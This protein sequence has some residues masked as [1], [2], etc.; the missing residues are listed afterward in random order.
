VSLSVNA[1]QA[2]GIEAGKHADVLA[3]KLGL[4]MT[5]YW[6]QTVESR[7]CRVSKERICEADKAA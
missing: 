6:Q 5:A 4:D 2:R 3:R 1:V 7:L